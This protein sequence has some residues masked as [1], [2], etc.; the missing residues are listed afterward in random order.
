MALPEGTYRIDI[1]EGISKV[2]PK[3]KLMFHTI[4]TASEKVKAGCKSAQDHHPW[5]AS[6]KTGWCTGQPVTWI[7]R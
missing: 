4:E 5:L 1:S 7:R 2:A 3:K 6:L